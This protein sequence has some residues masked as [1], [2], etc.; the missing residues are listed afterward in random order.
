MRADALMSEQSPRR[1]DL[2]SYAPGSPEAAALSSLV[3]RLDLLEKMDD[4][5]GRLDDRHESATPE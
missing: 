2:G 4:W 5:T 3:I 1:T